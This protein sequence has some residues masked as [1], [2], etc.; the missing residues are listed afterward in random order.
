MKIKR[1]TGTNTR[2]VLTRIRNDLGADAVILSNREIV[3]GV[4]LMAAVDFDASR[5]PSDEPGEGGAGTK[6]AVQTPP[7]PNP[8]HEWGGSEPRDVSGKRTVETVKASPPRAELSSPTRGGGWEGE[9]SAPRKPADDLPLPAVARVAAPVAPTA[10]PRAAAQAAPITLEQKDAA[11]LATAHTGAAADPAIPAHRSMRDPAAAMAPKD[12]LGAMR[13]ELQDLRQW[14]QSQMSGLADAGPLTPVG[15]Q[16]QALGFSTARARQLGSQALNLRGALAAYLGKGLQ[17]AAD[18]VSAAGIY[19][20][21]GPTGAGKTTTIAKL[22]ARLV[23]RHGTAAVALITTDTYRIG[24][25]EQLKIYGRILGVPVAVARD[26]EELQQHLRDFADRRY[27]LID[28]IGLSP[29][30]ARMA[31]QM[32]WLQA[33]GEGVTRLLVVGAGLA[34]SAYAEL[35]SLY[36][37]LPVA[38]AILTKLD[39]SPSFGAALQWLVEGSV[40]LW[41]YTDGQRVPEDLHVPSLAKITALLEHDPVTRFDSAPAPLAAAVGAITARTA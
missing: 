26:G 6:A 31:E 35:W 19:A 9:G 30:D 24:G 37:R 13:H 8:P 2:E 29:R 11:S 27:V 38:A 28:S 14:M 17:V 39:E 34:P 40:P 18:P 4:E 22:A 16:L 20:L 21:V 41:F 32:Q 23:L 3:G 25:V 33:L 10:V 5:F 7:H 36:R 12:E 1:Y 15:E